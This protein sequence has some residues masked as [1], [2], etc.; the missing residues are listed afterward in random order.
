MLD[1]IQEDSVLRIRQGLNITTLPLSAQE[2]FLLSRIDGS[3][4]VKDIYNLSMFDQSSTALLIKKLL[5]Q[6]ILEISEKPQQEPIG[7]EVTD[8]L[9]TR[10]FSG[11]IFN[12]MELEDEVDLPLAL[13]K[14]I[15]FLHDKMDSLNYYELLGLDSD[16]SDEEVKKAFIR[17]SKVYHPDSYFSKELGSYKS[18][19][20]EIYSKLAM[21]NTI[22]S[23]PNEKQEYRRQLIE[24]G[25]IDRKNDD[26]IED[27]I[28]RKIR[29]EKIR[30]TNRLHRNPM[31]QRV[32]KA[33]DFYQAGQVDMEK[34][35]WISAANNFKFAMM[36]D[37][38]NEL[39][40]AKAEQVRE[41]ANK[42]AA[43]KIY[44]RAL[45][46]ESFGQDGYVESFLKAVQMYPASPDFNMKVASHYAELG[47]WNEALP[48]AQRAAAADPQNIENRLFYCKTLL[49]LKKKQEATKECE[50][51]LKMAPEN[52]TAKKYLK[53]A[54]KWF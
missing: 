45:R 21:A 29:L 54:K 6:K 46:M 10:D 50:L 37:P 26:F 25:K 18:K 27:P 33:R 15:L 47:E 52:K 23:V 17:L 39:Y 38:S 41:M 14:E 30:K 7:K 1:I 34:E 3:L 22:L 32:K 19:I 9:T 43:T 28:E 13:K 5:D 49:G 42:A 53:D 31:L 12:L 36:H 4:T 16:A 35:A 2:G 24:N 11:Y 20:S 40:K 44:E 51:V 48:Y 8:L